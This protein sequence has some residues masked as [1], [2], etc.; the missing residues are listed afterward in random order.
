[1]M[2][3]WKV[4]LAVG[5]LAMSG[6]GGEE[7]A[8]QGLQ[9]RVTLEERDGV[10]I[11]QSNGIPDHP[12]GAFPN[13][14]NPNT[15]REQDYTFRMPLAPGAAAK[16]TAVPPHLFGVAVNGVPFDPGTAEFWN[17]DPMS[18]WNYDALSGQIDLGLDGNNAHVQPNGAYH[19]HG[20]PMG[21]AKSRARGDDMTLVGYAADGFPLY[22]VFGYVDPE[23]PASGIAQLHSSYQIREGQRPGGTEGPGGKYDGTFTQDFI[24]VAGSG[25]LDECNGRVGVTPEYPQG[26]YYY[27]L[28]MEYPFIPRLWRGEPDASFQ[29]QRPPIGGRDGRRGGPPGGGGGGGLGGRMPPSE[30]PGGGFP[31]P[32]DMR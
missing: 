19:Y 3:R 29:K 16:T 14:G 30:G 32:P 12:P 26:T 9:N 13:A 21:L 7:A 10:R 6:R 25:D 27:V 28:T 23:V 1:M 24:Y 20:V 5:L 17:R 4:A 18:G 2:L 11:I 31:P 22:A 8:A 15:I